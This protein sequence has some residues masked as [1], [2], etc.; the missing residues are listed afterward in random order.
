MECSI[1]YENLKA[2]KGGQ[3]TN[4]SQR[5]ITCKDSWVCGDCY[6]KWDCDINDTGVFYAPMPCVF[7]KTPMNY[8]NLV[9]KF[10]EGTG[11]GWWDLLRADKYEKIYDYLERVTELNN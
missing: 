9:S 6:H 8:S 1:C 11:A 7:C 4:W 3:E 5:C 10:N 2:E